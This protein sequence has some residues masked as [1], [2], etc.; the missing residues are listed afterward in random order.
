MKF[1][2]LSLSKFWRFVT[3]QCLFYLQ[4]GTP[5]LAEAQKLSWNQAAVP[6]TTAIPR[7]QL[8]PPSLGWAHLNP[9]KKLSAFL[10]RC[11]PA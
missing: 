3:L 2:V 5:S 4:I 10:R 1:S 8:H 9:T 7:P 11:A 6:A